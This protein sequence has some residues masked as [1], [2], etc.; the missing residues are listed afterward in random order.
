M[1]A[2]V[3]VAVLALAAAA[4]SGV[5]RGGNGG[6]ASGSGPGSGS[7]GGGGAA[8]MQL[9]PPPWRAD[10]VGLR[11]RLDAAGLAAL[12]AEGQVLHTHE[13]IDVLVDGKPVTV[14]A[15]IGINQTERFISPI[16][17]HDD[18]GIIH[19]ESPTLQE[20]TLGEFFDVWGVRFGDGCIGGECASGTRVLSVYVNG[21]AVTGDPRAL[22]L[23]P[24]QEIVVAMGTPAQLPNPVPAT[25]QF[26]EGL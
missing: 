9:G 24:H 11:A 25:F 26:P 13:H 8:V 20:F 22:V 4:V 5:G 14:P 19:V 1:G 7:A 21:T 3:V 10:T 15:N 6:A 12:S 2:V 23:A 18:S 17:T 16:H